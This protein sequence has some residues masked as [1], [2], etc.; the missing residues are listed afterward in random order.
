[1]SLLFA[2]SLGL[3]LNIHLST[4][5]AVVGNVTPKLNL[6][7][8]DAG[9]GL[10][11]ATYAPSTCQ[12]SFHSLAH[13]CDLVSS[14]HSPVYPDGPLRPS[15]CA[16]PTSFASYFSPMLNLVVG[17]AAHYLTSSNNITASVVR[18]SYSHCTSG[19]FYSA[20]VDPFCFDSFQPQQA[21]S[22][23]GL[24]H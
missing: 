19:S 1:L 22:S 7:Y 20:Q 23:H 2:V 24:L 14:P 5:L 10:A 18:P 11:S 13:H 17:L 6:L 9:D 15:D 21:Y 16:S 4:L 12:I 3:D 8:Q